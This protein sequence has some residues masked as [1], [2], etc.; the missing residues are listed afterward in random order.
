MKR[1]GLLILAV[2]S[3]L[4][5]V[6]GQNVDD[7][8][9][10]SN[11]FYGGT[12][13]S[14]SMGGAFTALGGDASTLNQNP[15]G[16]GVFRSS[17][18]TITPQLL[19]NKT[20]AYYNGT[21]TSTT[22]NNFN[23]G[24]FGIIANVLSKPSGLMSFNVGYAFN[25][26][27]NLHQDVLIQGTNN[28]S[29]MA[30]YWANLGNQGGGTYYKDLQ[31]AEGIAFD[32]WVIDTLTGSGGYRYGTVY[33]NYGDNPPSRYGQQLRRL[34]Y[35]DGYIGENSISFGGNYSNKI[36][37]GGTFGISSLRYTSDYEHLESTDVPLAS[38]FK[39]FTYTDYYEDRG[40]GYSFKLGLIY[41]PVDMVRLG[42]AFH[43][44]TWYK[45]DEYFF[46]DI[47]SN[48]TDGGHYEFH[49]EPMRFNY[50][51]ATPYRLLAGIGV[52]IKKIALVSVDYEYVDYSK[53]KF[54]QT[55][56]GYNY[57][58]KNNEIANSLKAVN[59]FRGGLELRFDKL[60][61]RGGYGY[62]GKAF[63]QTEDNA[64][65]DYTTLS[66]GIGFR[67]KNL[68]IDF[69]YMNFKYNDKYILYPVDQYTEPAISNL[70]TVKN[71]FTLTFG[72]RFGV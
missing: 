68:S 65:L 37:F 53:A 5:R 55:G 56:D 14:Y 45:I 26:T 29:S 50:A 32:A 16:I 27:N 38:K 3:L 69:G 13:R 33:S 9:R 30:D 62:Y 6:N 19:Y 58:D 47:T 52:Q 17:E 24:Q 21:S 8:I 49:N 41:K 66:G 4:T 20:S 39:N 34:I 36:F 59:N 31:N 25:R 72:Y 2:L 51:L 12:A 7:A 42:F 54:S 46:N 61:L 44:P 18:I 71:I 28:T 10:Y 23:I 70:S 64:Q 67:E 35:N 11:I 57:S 63:N 1:I 43:S 60:Y 15:A 40:T 22:L 48:F